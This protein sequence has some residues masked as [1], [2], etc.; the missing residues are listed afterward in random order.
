[1]TL[2]W[3]SLWENLLIYTLEPSSQHLAWKTLAG[4]MRTCHI[5]RALHTPQPIIARTIAHIHPRRRRFLALSALFFNAGVQTMWLETQ[6]GNGAI[7]IYEDR[8][9]SEREKISGNWALE[10]M[11]KERKIYEPTKKKKRRR[12]RRGK[13]NGKCCTAFMEIKLILLIMHRRATAAKSFS[14]A[15]AITMHK[16]VF[17]FCLL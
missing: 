7:W 17:V 9:E 3:N 11:E 4:D 14:L 15:L 16:Q 2:E 10:V 8:V 1:M 5:E 12:G 6:T 13:R